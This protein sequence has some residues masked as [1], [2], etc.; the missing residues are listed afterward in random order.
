MNIKF[1]NQPKDLS[2]GEILNEKLKKGFQKVWFIAGV[3]KDTGI[4][5]LLESIEEARNLGTE[6]NFLVGIDRKNISK[7][8]LMKLLN[9]GCNLSL[10]INRDDNK[11]ETRIYI[12]ESKDGESFIYESSGKFSEGGLFT[13]QLVVQEIS[14]PTSEKKAFENAKNI[15]LQGAEVF[16]ATDEEE[17][18]LLAE[19]GE[20]VARITE[21]KIPSIS[22]MYGGTSIDAISNDIYDESSSGKLF[23]IPENDFDIDIDI[24]IDGEVRKAEL[25]VETEAKK[26]KKEKENIEK[27]AQEK[28]SKFYAENYEE[29]P[30]KR[31]SII[32]DMNNIDFSKVNIFVVEL[33]RIV[34]KGLGEGEIKIPIYLYEE[35]AEFFG[36][37]DF[38]AFKDDKDKERLG[39]ITKFE[40]VDANNNETKEDDEA[41]IYV[42]TRH[43]AL[44]SKV[45][46][47]LKPSEKDIVRII[48]KGDNSF[49]LE[50]IRKDSKEYDIWDNFCIYTMKNSKRKFGIM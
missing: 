32:K 50:L 27:L 3:A 7:D 33:N 26:E 40:I 28:L 19:K 47:D 38:K 21:R 15:I 10:H 18:K 46:K 41:L 44:K 2:L 4:E 31:V 30:E 25:S 48:K 34:E 35:M 43:L 6:V 22:E 12:F 42:E 37:K 14:Y 49:C 36:G 29:E 8:M 17:L 45:F 23:D 1:W 24:D 9:M 13:S 20:V 39:I 5:M 16:K 11:V